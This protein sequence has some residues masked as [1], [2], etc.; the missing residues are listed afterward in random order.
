MTTS[1]SAYWILGS[2]PLVVIA[3]L[4]GQQLDIG[5]V[6]MAVIRVGV[7]SVKVGLRALRAKL[8]EN[9]CPHAPSRPSDSVDLG[10]EDWECREGMGRIGRGQRDREGV[11]GRKDN[12]REGLDLPVLIAGPSSCMMGRRGRQAVKKTLKPK[13]K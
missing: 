13:K 7:F 6:A 1:T 2:L 9:K 11:D 8:A 4:V 12:E 5:H 3:V 10:R